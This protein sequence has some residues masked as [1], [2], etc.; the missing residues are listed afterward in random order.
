MVIVKVFV[1]EIY[2]L[3]EVLDEVSFVV[4]ESGFRSVLIV[5]CICCDVLDIEVMFCG[6]FSVLRLFLRLINLF[7]GCGFGMVVKI[8]LFVEDLS[9][10]FKR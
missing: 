1:L 4:V 7:S 3:I 2:L 10:W 8:V 5:C 6:K 9:V